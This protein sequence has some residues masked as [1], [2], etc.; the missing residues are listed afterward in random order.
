MGRIPLFELEIANK[1][2]YKHEKLF[3]HHLKV[4][5]QIVLMLYALKEKLNRFLVQSL[6]VNSFLNSSS[7]SDGFF[8]VR[9][10]AAKL[11]QNSG[12]LE[13]LFKAL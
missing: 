9:L 13:F 1:T 3:V 6:L 7:T 5:I 8:L 4:N 10:A 11:L 12:L 2:L